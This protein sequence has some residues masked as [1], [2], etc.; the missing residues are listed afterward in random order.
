[1][2]QFRWPVSFWRSICPHLPYCH[3][4][5]GLTDIHY[6]ICTWILLRFWEFEL[7]SWSLYSQCFTHFVVFLALNRYSLLTFFPLSRFQNIIQMEIRRWWLF[8]FNMVLGFNNNSSKLP[9]LFNSPPESVQLWWS[10]IRFCLGY[11]VGPLH[12]FLSILESSGEALTNRG[13]V[14]WFTTSSLPLWT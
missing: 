13:F 9:L 6:C 11:M 4:N 10:F 3:R 5:S 12:T 1:M 14:F 7:R 2:Y 8:K